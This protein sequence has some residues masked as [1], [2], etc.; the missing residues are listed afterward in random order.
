[1]KQKYLFCS[2]QVYFVVQIIQN[3]FRI[4]LI[5]INKPALPWKTSS[6]FMESVQYLKIQFTV[7]LHSAPVFFTARL[8]S[9]LLNSNKM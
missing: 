3:M 6:H 8:L 4:K 7:N 9:A 2:I 1:M 5:D